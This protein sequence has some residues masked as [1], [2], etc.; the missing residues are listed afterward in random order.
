MF[1]QGVAS[2]QAIMLLILTIVL[3][4]LYVKYVYREV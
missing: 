1:D 4:R 3:A 2:A